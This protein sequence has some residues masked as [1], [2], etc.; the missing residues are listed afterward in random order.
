MINKPPP[1]KGLHIRIPMVILIE[2]VSLSLII[3]LK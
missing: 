1:F 2:V 3:P